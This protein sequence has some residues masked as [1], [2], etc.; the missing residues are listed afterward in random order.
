MESSLHLRLIAYLL[1]E[2]NSF[3][4]F[5]LTALIIFYLIKFVVEKRKENNILKAS[6][7]QFQGTEVKENN[8][9]KFF[10]KMFL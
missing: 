1:N 8:L 2:W 9:S 6:K 7:T 10:L 3:D 5:C 4:I